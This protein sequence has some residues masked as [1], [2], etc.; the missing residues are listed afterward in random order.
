MLKNKLSDLQLINR[1]KEQQDSVAITELAE[2]HTGIYVSAVSQYSFVPKVERD[3][4]LDHRLYNI[5]KYALDFDPSKDVKFSTYVGHRIRWECQTLL[6]TIPN[7]EELDETIPDEEKPM[8]D[9][10]VETMAYAEELAAKI[11]DERFLKIFQMRH[12]QSARPAFW[13]VIGK[14]LGMSHEYARKIYN[15]YI[16]VITEQLKQNNL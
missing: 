3:E 9:N 12:P 4:L 8:I 5:Y 1:V 15:K 13:R 11:P 7:V 6:S 16:G 10:N 2:R 14:N